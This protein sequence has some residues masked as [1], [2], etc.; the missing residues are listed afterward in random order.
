MKNLFLALILIILSN[1]SFS[2]ITF[3]KIIGLEDF[4]EIPSDMIE[5]ETGNCILLAR[6][7]EYDNNGIDYTNVS[8]LSEINDSGMVVKTVIFDNYRLWEIA[9]QNDKF[10]AT[11]YY[12]NGDICKILFVILDSEY[13]ITQVSDFNNTLSIR[14]LQIQKSV[15][16]VA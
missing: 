12:I 14:L 4:N 6:Y 5:L 15:K 16:K 3:K 9:Q 11:G 8:S 2:Q 7:I 13:N 1:L 10:I